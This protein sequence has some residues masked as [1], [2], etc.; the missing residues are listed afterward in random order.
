[1]CPPDGVEV[2]IAELEALRLIDYMDKTF[3]EAAKAMGA[4]KATVW[5]LVSTARRKIVQA[6]VEGRPICIVIGGVIEPS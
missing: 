2:T 5:R 3:E 6:I 1:M 4:S